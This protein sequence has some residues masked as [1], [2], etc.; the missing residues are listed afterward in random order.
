MLKINI[1]KNKKQ[2]YS[3]KKRGKIMDYI[4]RKNITTIP[5]YGIDIA[6]HCDKMIKNNLVTNIYRKYDLWT[7]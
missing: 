5:Q 6:I 2:W 7:H 3:N 1:D 4:R